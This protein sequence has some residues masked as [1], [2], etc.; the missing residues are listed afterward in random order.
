MS[1]P[2]TSPSEI[3]SRI[4]PAAIIV[5]VILRLD[6]H[7]LSP[8]ATSRLCMINYI[9]LGVD[10]VDLEPVAAVSEHA[11]GMYFTL[12]RKVLQTHKAIQGGMWTQTSVL[13]DMMRD[14][15]GKMLMNCSEEVV[16]II[17]Q[18][19]RIAQLG[20]KLSIKVLVTEWKHPLS[21][22]NIISN[23]TPV[24][25]FFVNVTRGGVVDEPALYRA[26]ME[27][28]I[29]VAGVDVFGKE[30]DTEESCGLLGEGVQQLGLSLITT[31]HT[32]WAGDETERKL[33]EMALENVEA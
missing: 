13:N 15:D 12:R 30:P 31:P 11:I 17:G 19:Q 22:T 16:G 25:C 5:V 33:R 7:H 10:G 14:E 3:A 8:G 23:E 2:N 27:R 24:H 21:D 32:L 9:A 26:L 6:I 29:A 20:R 4:F 18:G 28:R 1:Y